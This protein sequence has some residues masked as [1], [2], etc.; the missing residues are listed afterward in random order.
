MIE[1]RIDEADLRKIRDK[2]DKVDVSKRGVVI[3]KAF[4]MATLDV[5]QQL[6]KNVTGRH[7]KV[8]TGHL[9]N[10]IGSKIETKQGEIVGIVGSGVRTGK[11]V[12]YANIHETGGT[13]KPKTAK[14]LTVPLPAALTP[15]GV[16]K[17]PAR[18]WDNT[19]FAKSGENLFLMQKQGKKVVPLF[20]LKKEVTIPASHYLAETVQERMATVVRIMMTHIERGLQ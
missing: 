19:F 11:R 17:K 20:V 10:S 18:E 7:L 16:L 8:R 3:I 1:A 13:I 2:L 15:A 14:F 4:Q 5:E 6:K 12:K 9:R